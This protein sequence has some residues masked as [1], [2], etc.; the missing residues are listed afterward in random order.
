MIIE[1]PDWCVIGKYI[2]VK[3]F[4]NLLGEYDWF[5]QRILS[6]SENGFFHQAYN[7]PVHHNLFSDYGVSVRE[8][9]R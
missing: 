7:C 9:E 1:V 5:C 8:C 2:E 3:M 6:Y 4:D